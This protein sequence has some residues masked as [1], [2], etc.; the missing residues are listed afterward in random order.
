[1]RA[2]FD[3][4]KVT[5]LSL[6]ANLLK[7]VKNLRLV[8]QLYHVRL[9]CTGFDSVYLLAIVTGT[10][11]S[12]RTDATIPCTVPTLISPNDQRRNRF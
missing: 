6:R 5:C 9:Y 8:P 7:N 4:I 12:N 10:S 1:M 11:F 2:L 3:D